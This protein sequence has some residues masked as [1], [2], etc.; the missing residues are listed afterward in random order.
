M[1]DPYAQFNQQHGMQ[2]N[3]ELQNAYQNQHQLGQT[4]C[5]YGSNRMPHGTGIS[6][7]PGHSFGVSGGSPSRECPGCVHLNS[8]IQQLE[9]EKASWVAEIARLKAN[10]SGAKNSKPGISPPLSR[11][12]TV[13]PFIDSPLPSIALPDEH[14][15]KAMGG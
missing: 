5:Y 9:A 11:S 2:N 3:A 8:I 14:F 1:S 7:A 4:T 15:R 10:M 12:A 13:Q 6:T